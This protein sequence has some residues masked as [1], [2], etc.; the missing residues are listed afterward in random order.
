M[1]KELIE[2]HYRENFKRLVGQMSQSVGFHNAEDIIQDAYVHC[3]EYYDG[4]GESFEDWFNVAC[5]HRRV[6][7]VRKE[8]RLGMTREIAQDAVDAN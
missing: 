6:D 8:R 2:E 4:Q 1:Y 5:Y 3:L 7:H